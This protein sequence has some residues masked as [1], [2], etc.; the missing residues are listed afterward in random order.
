MRKIIFVSRLDKDC[1][2]GAYLLCE[3]AQDLLKKYNDIQIMIIGGGTE[4]KKIAEISQKINKK[5]N[6]KLIIATGAVTNPTSFFEKSSLFVGVSRAALEAMAHGLPV[7]LLGNEGYLGLLN[8]DKLPIA[9]QS[10]FTCRNSSKKCDKKIL[11][12]EICHYFELSDRQKQHLADLSYQTIKNEYNSKKMAQNTLNVYNKALNHYRKSPIYPQIAICGYYGHGNLGDEA[13]LD[14]VSSKIRTKLPDSKIYVLNSNN[15]LKNLYYLSKSEF[16]LFGGGSLLQNSTSNLSFFYYITIIK[17]AHLL[18]KK[19]FMIS[20]GIG[21]IRCNLFT[22]TMFL[23]IIKNTLKSFDFISVRDTISQDFL[24]NLVPDIKIHLFPDPALIEA[25][26]INHKLI[27]QIDRKYFVYIPCK[28]SLVDSQISIEILARSIEKISKHFSLT[29]VICVLN[30][31]TDAKFSQKLTTLISGAK[32]I[33]PRSPK[34]LSQSIKKAKFVISQRYHGS[35]FA[36]KCNTPIL[37]VS[38]DP[39]LHGLCKDFGLF[40]TQSIN[41]FKNSNK[42][43]TN[44]SN[45]LEYHSKCEKIICENVKTK[46][47]LSNAMF[48]NILKYFSEFS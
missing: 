47:N 18:C 12:D 10:N 9:Q 34:S 14:N 46:T 35:L 45:L 20:N 44:I 16:F 6:Y 40:P 19:S 1:S 5:S 29:P 30:T 27:N 41:I 37:S 13:I 33:Y 36:C 38:S 32:I 48:E 2:L 24:K 39:K 7:I 31:N 28:K 26:Q 25:E 21:P 22:E 8:E 42:L 15:I 4:Y 11:F 43:T 23:N 17:V 3:I